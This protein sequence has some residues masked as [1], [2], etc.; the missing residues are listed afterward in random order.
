MFFHVSFNHC[1]LPCPGGWPG[2]GVGGVAASTAVVG[3]ADILPRRAH[4][5]Q[6]ERHEFTS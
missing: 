6:Q 1:V 4:N 5:E 3:A 2:P